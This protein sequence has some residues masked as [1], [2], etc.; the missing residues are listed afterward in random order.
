MESKKQEIISLIEE[1]D[2]EGLDKLLYFIKLQS[3][4][5]IITNITSS[6]EAKD[7]WNDVCISIRKELTE[8]SY[9]TW[10][11]NI[12]PVSI[13]EDIFTLAV[14]NEFQL[15]IIK[16]RYSNLIKTALLYVTDRKFELEYVVGS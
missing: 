8:V 4:K 16:G 11:S 6:V 1:M 15:G 13:A 14:E 2:E 5:K 3:K 12:T 9:N 7:I 10:I